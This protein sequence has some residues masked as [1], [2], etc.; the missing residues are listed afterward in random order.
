[1]LDRKLVERQIHAQRNTADIVFVY[2]RLL[3]H[4]RSTALWLFGH[5][6]MKRLL[7]LSVPTI[8]LNM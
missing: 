6:G 4:E 1:M 3:A 2:P 5:E 7:R 8:Q